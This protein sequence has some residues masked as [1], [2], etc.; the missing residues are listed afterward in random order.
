[1]NARER[2]RLATLMGR[3]RFS[4]L[5]H[6][7]QAHK[8]G[9]RRMATPP[10]ILKRCAEWPAEAE[11]LGIKQTEAGTWTYWGLDLYAHE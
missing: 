3:T 7:Y 9:V 2:Q 8:P 5:A 4:E 6:W 1:L 10:A 11:S